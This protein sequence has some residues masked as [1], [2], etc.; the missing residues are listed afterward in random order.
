MYKF[1]NI[2]FIALVILATL[3]VASASKIQSHAAVKSDGSGDWDNG[4]T[5]PKLEINGVD[6]GEVKILA[7]QVVKPTAENVYHM[8]FQ[9][10]EAPKAE[11]KK[12]GR[13]FGNN[14]WGLSYRKS[15]A[16]FKFVNPSGNKFIAGYIYNEAG[17][18]VSFKLLLP[19]KFIGWYIN[20]TQGTA[21]ATG[22]NKA[23]I[24]R[25]S[26]VINQKDILSKNYANYV[27]TADNLDQVTNQKDGFEAYVK[28]RETKLKAF[29]T[30]IG[31]LRTTA[32]AK[33]KTVNENQ[34]SL[35]AADTL[36]NELIREASQLGSQ[37]NAIDE[38]VKK[39]EDAKSDIAKTKATLTADV[40]AAKTEI[41]K[42]FAA[43][44][45]NAPTRKTEIDASKAALFAAN[46][47]DFISNINKIYPK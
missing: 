15:C 46:K 1:I 28:A 41:T 6:Q 38:A 42:A 23:S 32:E 29:K 40:D 12:L 8:M 18:I 9:F 17:K 43:L 39:I 22:M 21:I 10:T 26:A 16:H 20:D 47:A 33:Q 7:K 5:C 3:S 4:Y 25:T 13:D 19:W 11:F 30:Q 45:G 37:K 34:H 14:K 2:K 36:I 31:A 44:L 24:D 35:Q 27:V